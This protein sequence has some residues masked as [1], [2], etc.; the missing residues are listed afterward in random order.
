VL[1]NLRFQLSFDDP[2]VPEDKQV[3]IRGDRTQLEALWEAVSAYVQKILSQSDDLALPLTQTP[4]QPGDHV[5]PMVNGNSEPALIDAASVEPAPP[6]T[7]VPHLESS[8]PT[9]G[10]RATGNPATGIH[11]QPKGWLRHELHLGTIA[12][13]RSA[14]VVSLSALQLFDLANALDEYHA[15]S[16]TLPTLNRP[17][18]AKSPGGWASIAAVL[19]LAIGST[20]ALTKFVSD[21]SSPSPQLA[22]AASPE[23]G[24]ATTGA[25]SKSA[26]RL[27]VPPGIEPLPSSLALQPLPP[28]PPTGATKST[29]PPER[30]IVPQTPIPAPIAPGD[31]S[32]GQ[33]AVIPQE[34]LPAPNLSFESPDSAAIASAESARSA[35]NAALPESAALRP[36]TLQS[37]ALPSDSGQPGAEAANGTAFDAIPQVA[38]VRNYF[39][40]S[41]QA[42]EGLT[43]TLEYRLVLN[44]DGSLQR[45][46]P[47]GQ[48]AATFLDRT[49]MPLLNEPFVSPVENGTPQIRLVLGQDGKVQTFLEGV[50]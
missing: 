50:R 21:V 24:G 42:P 20:A 35:P 2:T 18:W 23:A 14:E 40:G 39:Q 8:N 26:E 45:I 37:D 41:W 31:F 3:E 30:T 32:S 29:A 15:E 10:N 46:I 16:L 43:Q 34:A 1:K 49:N 6:L 27:P 22:T 19:L 13:D 7:L 38:E 11:L 4:D 12:T 9:I 36:E 47:L 44:S 48:A 28:I 25:Q 17:A 5:S 33:V